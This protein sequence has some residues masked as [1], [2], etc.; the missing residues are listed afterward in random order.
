MLLAQL[1][2][3]SYVYPESRG[4]IPGWVVEDLLDRA[5]ADLR[6]E[7]TDERV[8]RG[9]L[10][11]RFSFAIDVNEWGFRDFCE[12]RTSAAERE[13]AVRAIAASDV[14]DQRSRA[15]EEYRVRVG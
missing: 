11:S 1:Q 2:V 8:T 9:T 14:W 6:R 13:P 5:R 7:R 15:S 12:E 10:V 4:A 3:F